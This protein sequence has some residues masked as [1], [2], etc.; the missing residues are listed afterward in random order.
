[1]NVN[2]LIHPITVK[3]LRDANGPYFSIVAGRRRIAAAYLLGWNEIACNVL[4][5]HEEDKAEAISGSENINRLAMHPLDEAAIFQKLVKSGASIE[6]LA[7]RYDRPK[8]AIWQR[9]QLLGLNDVIKDYF[10]RG[11]ISLHAAAMLKGLD[12]KQ[13]EKFVLEY[14]STSYIVNDY[15]GEIPQYE[16]ESFIN[17]QNH[18]RLY[19]HIAGKECASCAKRTFYTDKGLF[20]ELDS[21]GDFCLDHGCYLERV[22][23][24][25]FKKIKSIEKKSPEHKGACIVTHNSEFKKAFVKTVS[26]GGAGYEVKNYKYGF[27]MAT[28]KMANNFMPCIEVYF[29]KGEFLMNPMWYKEPQKEKQG[30]EKSGFAPAVKLLGL[31]KDEAAKAVEAFEGSKK[32]TSYKFNEDVMERVYLRAVEYKAQ[33]GGNDKDIVFLLKNLFENFAQEGKKKICKLFNVSEDPEEIKKLPLF[34]LFAFLN[35][36]LMG[37]YNVPVVEDVLKGKPNEFVEWAGVP[38][39]KLKLW[40]QEE[41]RALMPK[42]EASGKE[43]KGKQAKKE[44]KKKNKGVQKCRVCGC[45]DDDCSGCIEKTGEPCH[46]VEDD[47][48]SAC[49][50]ELPDSPEAA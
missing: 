45:T 1:M 7:R 36:C 47:L 40:Y 28:S 13:Q 25:V 31:P 19:K 10:R 12:P 32:T 27:T 8:H 15:E 4:E 11:K 37:G 38:M 18:D 50:G 16:I 30:K 14:R 41:I 48:C 43:G 24:L 29:D 33:Q 23:K 44:S 49:V 2:G 20:P 42:P 6:S 21:S 3:E 26:E 46:C 39:D 22:N 5:P 17:K 9:L 35:A 34:K